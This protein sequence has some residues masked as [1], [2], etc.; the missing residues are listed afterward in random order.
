MTAIGHREKT[1]AEAGPRMIKTG[2]LRPHEYTPHK[3]GG[4]G[5]SVAGTVAWGVDY[6]NRRPVDIRASGK[7]S[8]HFG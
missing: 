7:G 4:W 5:L 1:S 6:T 3:A 2:R 8:T